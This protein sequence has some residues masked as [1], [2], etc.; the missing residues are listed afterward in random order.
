MSMD[1]IRFNIRHIP[2]YLDLEGKEINGVYLTSKHV[3]MFGLI[4]FCGSGPMGCIASTEYFAEYFGISKHSVQTIRGDLARAGLI[5]FE[6]RKGTTEIA[7]IFIS[8]LEM[9]L[10]NNRETQQHS[11]VNSSASGSPKSHPH[12]RVTTPVATPVGKIVLK[13]NLM[14][15]A[16]ANSELRSELSSS[17][18]K[19]ELANA[20]SSSRTERNVVGENLIKDG[21]SFLDESSIDEKSIVEKSSKCV[22]NRSCSTPIPTSVEHEHDVTGVEGPFAG[23]VEVDDVRSSKIAKENRMAFAIARKVYDKMGISA[24]PGVKMR[25][26]V[27][28]RLKEGYTE[29]DILNCLAWCEKDEFYKENKDPMSWTSESALAKYQMSKAPGNGN[30]SLENWTK[31]DGDVSANYTF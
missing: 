9:V 30:Y 29:E 18:P 20:R 7:K 5:R 6:R 28:D 31:V 11:G 25:N 27:L 23:E 4:A 26:R 3:K 15:S 24:K 17:L 10:S 22:P 14:D 12:R 19:E 1:R 2:Y 8:D 13:N 21:N 16:S